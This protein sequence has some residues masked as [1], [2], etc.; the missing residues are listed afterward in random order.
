MKNIQAT[1][2]VPYYIY[3]ATETTITA[4][5]GKV[6][7]FTNNDG[8][9]R[10]HINGGSRYVTKDVFEGGMAQLVAQGATVIVEHGFNVRDH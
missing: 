5:D 9:E 10:W 2:K 4:K 6:I 3:P 8:S 1:K 7:A